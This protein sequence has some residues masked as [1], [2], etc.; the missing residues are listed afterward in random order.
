MKLQLA[1]DLLGLEEALDLTEQV[2]DFVDIIEIGTPFLI[3]EGMAAVR[4]FRR[5]FP[6][7]TIL[8]DAKIMDAGDIEAASA[9][10]AG[11]DMVTVLGVT[12]TLTVRSCVEAAERFDGQVVAD[13]IC[14]PDLPARIR[15]LE[16]AGVHGLAVHTGVDQ[17]R[18]G[19]TPL[20]DLRVM[21]AHSRAAHISVAG[22]IS[23]ETIPAYAGLSPDI[24]IVGSRICAASD[25]FAAAKAIR[26]AMDACGKGAPERMRACGTSKRD[27]HAGQGGNRS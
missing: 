9:F 27:L 1:L 24:L 15:A 18:A 5:R 21:K 17:Q 16:A 2:R 3:E 10:R 26:E 4:R 13:M 12:D 7:K 11:A 23:L 25:P 22:G 6:D 20:D 19:R 8:V 14:V